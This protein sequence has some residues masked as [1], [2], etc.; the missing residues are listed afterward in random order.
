MSEDATMALLVTSGDGPDECCLAVEHIVERMQAEAL[1]AGLELSCH[2]IAARHGAKSAV[3]MVAGPDREA[4][5]TRWV[6]TIQWRMRSPLR[7]QHKR[8]NWFVGVFRLQAM[9]TGANALDAREVTFSTLRAGGPGGQHQN[10]TD[11]AVRV[12]HGPSGISVVVRD[13]RSQHQNK[14][15]AL[16]RLQAMLDAKSLADLE[17]QKSQQNRLHR[18]LE[19]GN[20]LR[21]FKGAEFKEV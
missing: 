16:E 7:P 15:L 8:A 13:G 20:P 12:V 1:S 9:P 18:A 4:F 10:T 17:N 2:R 19:R 11:S 6:G 21:T 14:K 3:V 5:A